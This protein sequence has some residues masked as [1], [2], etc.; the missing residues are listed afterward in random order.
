MNTNWIR[1][2]G[3]HLTG[4]MLQGCSSCQLIS[5]YFSRK[6]SYAVVPL[7]CL[8]SCRNVSCTLTHLKWLQMSLFIWL[9][10]VQKSCLSQF[11]PIIFCSLHNIYFFEDHCASPPLS[12]KTLLSD[13]PHSSCFWAHW[14][15]LCYLP[16]LQPV[17]IFFYFQIC[18]S[19]LD[20]MYHPL[21]V[22]TTE[23]ELPIFVLWP[24][25]YI[26]I[27]E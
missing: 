8:Q 10:W 12:E 14:P 4:T 18:Y 19:R 2:L 17:D 23:E 3:S 6:V 15:F 1:D 25:L 5:S 9:N 11:K 27:S 22:H 26:F 13:L 24:C 7:S 20:T 21:L 16:F